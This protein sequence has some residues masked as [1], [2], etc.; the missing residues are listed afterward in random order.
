MGKLHHVCFSV[1]AGGTKTNG[2]EDSGDE[3]HVIVHEVFVFQYSPF[4][5][6]GHAEKTKN[7]RFTFLDRSVVVLQGRANVLFAIQ[8]VFDSQPMSYFVEHYVLE[9]S[10]EVDMFLLIRGN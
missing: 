4:C 3:G 6:F 1:G 2:T 5:E 9:E 7:V 8:R 10:V